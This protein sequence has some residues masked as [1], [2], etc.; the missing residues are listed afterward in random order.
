[1]LM[2]DESKVTA[3]LKQCRGCDVSLEEENAQPVGERGY[4]GDF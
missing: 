4:V 3:T 2:Y 1:M